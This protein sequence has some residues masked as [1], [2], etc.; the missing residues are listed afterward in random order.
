MTKIWYI[1]LDNPDEVREML[2]E[3]EWGRS[4]LLE[5]LYLLVCPLCQ[6]TVIASDD[7]YDDGKTMRQSHIDYHVDL[8]RTLQ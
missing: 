4:Y 3:G 7:P 1:Q 5:Q 8:A 2:E 6:A